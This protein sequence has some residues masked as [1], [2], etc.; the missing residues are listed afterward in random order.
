M[1]KRIINLIAGLVSGILRVFESRNPVAL[2]EAEKGNL[3]KQIV[4]FN[5]GLSEQAGVIYSLAG[6]AQKAL[7][8]QK[9]TERRIGILLEAGDRQSAAKQALKLNE[10]QAEVQELQTRCRCA[11]E[12]Y[13]ALEKARDRAVEEA[14]QR[15]ARLENLVSQT[16]ILNAQNELAQIAGG[17]TRS[18][19]SDENTLAHSE[20]VIE[21]NLVQAQGRSFFIGSE[22]RRLENDSE[23]A[24][25]EK[26]ILEKRALAEYL[27]RNG[28]A[29]ASDEQ[30]PGKVVICR[31][32][33]K[34]AA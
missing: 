33:R 22:L 26:S 10:F 11:E 25:A 23:T 1:F 2:I 21:K 9:E 27:A 29:G 4:K 12:S 5:D 28:I 8:T 14:T 24:E 34:S 15:I 18:I 7:Q 13:R 16:E 3:R 30:V 17:I 20:E 32:E 19:G 6:K 31:T